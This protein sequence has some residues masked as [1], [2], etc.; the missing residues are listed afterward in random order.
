LTTELG[1]YRL[2][3]NAPDIEYGGWIT[4]RCVFYSV[5]TSEGAFSHDSSPTAFHSHPTENQYADMPSPKDVYWLLKRASI[6]QVIVGGRHIIVLEKTPRTLPVVMKLF[7]W[8]GRHM[9]RTIDSLCADDDWASRNRSLSESYSE[10]A[11][12]RLIDVGDIGVEDYVDWGDWVNLLRKNLKVRV[13]RF[14]RKQK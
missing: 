1:V 8:E 14:A 10:I 5:G 4:R 7:E 9:V 2:L 6:R 3:P 13:R 11:L 12:H